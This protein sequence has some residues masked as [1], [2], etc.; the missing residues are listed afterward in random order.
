MVTAAVPSSVH[1]SVLA[2]KATKNRR[3]IAKIE[4]PIDGFSLTLALGAGK[5]KGAGHATQAI[6]RKAPDDI[7]VKAILEVPLS[8]LLER[9]VGAH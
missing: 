1:A 9:A 4:V 2:V 8:T 5:L 6:A 7:R 3:P